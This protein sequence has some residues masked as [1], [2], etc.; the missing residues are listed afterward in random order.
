MMGRGGRG[1]PWGGPMEWEGG[2]G[3]P[4]GGPWAGPGAPPHGDGRPGRDASASR[5]PPRRRDASQPRSVGGSEDDLGGGDGGDVEAAAALAPS[6]AAVAEAVLAFVASPV[7]LPSAEAR[8]ARCVAEQLRFAPTPAS[9][10][11]PEIAAA[12]AAA[13]AAGGIAYALDASGAH[14]VDE[15]VRRLMQGIA[16]PAPA[17]GGQDQKPKAAV[18]LD[19]DALFAPCRPV[20][21]GAELATLRSGGKQLMPLPLATLR[22]AAAARR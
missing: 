20:P 2:A 9:L 13:R 17:E 7:E 16:A 6:A 8:D 11:G 3:G 1:G 18:P 22:E 12:A 21:P 5:S 10:V 4:G 15:E 19:M 14:A